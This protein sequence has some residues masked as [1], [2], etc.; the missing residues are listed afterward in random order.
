MIG[1][2]AAGALTLLPG[3]SHAQVI[4]YNSR[5]IFLSAITGSTT[6]AF[7]GLAP[8]AFQPEYS[9][10]GSATVSGVTFSS[11][12]PNT[13]SLFN[14]QGTSFDMGT[15][16]LQVL[17][18]NSSGSAGPSSLTITLPTLEKALGFD[19]GSLTTD[20]FSYT[21]SNGQK[22]TFSNGS[23]SSLAFFGITSTTAFNSITITVNNYA[24]AYDNITYS[25]T[26][27]TTS[28][29]EPATLGLMATGLFAIGA[30]VRRRKAA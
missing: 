9:N 2:A 8:G 24:T 19:F 25:T 3:A 22:G 18:P 13:L 6:L 29:P 16:V 15:Q 10:G 12:A 17:T 7:S 26:L 28:T 30:V 27:A 20:I 11:P 21:L 5:S 4:T 1:L 23:A 14:S